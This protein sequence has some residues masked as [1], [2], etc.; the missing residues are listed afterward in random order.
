MSSA[1]ASALASASAAASS[2]SAAASAFEASVSAETLRANE[3]AAAELAKVSGGG[4]AGADVSLRGKPRAETGGLLAV[5]VSI[6]N[7]TDKK[8]SYAVQVDF[9][10]AAGKVVESR[11]V[12]GEDLAPGRLVQ[13]LAISRKPADL[14]LTPRIAK[15]QRY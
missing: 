4:N 2:A 3:A 6:T 14:N 8:A 13:P 7:R 15:A 11:I 1:A 5:I 10:D 9:T 12:G